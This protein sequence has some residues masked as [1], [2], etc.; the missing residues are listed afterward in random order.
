MI[1]TKDTKITAENLNAWISAF[2]H[3]EDQQPRLIKLGKYYDGINEIKKQGA[4]DGR[5]NYSIHVNLA[6]FITNVQTGYFMGKP[7][8][9]DFKEK[10]KGQENPLK[11][12]LL[13]IDSNN[14]AEEKN[15][16]LASDMSCYGVAYEVVMIDGDNENK[17]DILNRIKF[18]KLDAENTFLVVDDSI[19]QNPVCAVYM[20]AVKN[21][22]NV[23]EWRGYIYTADEIIEFNML[24]NQAVIGESYQHQFGEIPVIEYKNNCDRKGDYEAVTDQLDALSLTISNET[25]DLQ[26]I[27]NAILGI[28]G[29]TGTGDEVIKK[30]NETKVAKLP[31]GS[32]MEFVVK[33]INIDAV[34]HQIDQN[35]SLIYQ[36]TQTPDLTDENFG[37]TQT[38]VAMKYKLWGIEQCRITK[39]RY[40]RRSLFQRLRLIFNILS[41]SSGSIYDISQNIDFIFYKNLPEN[42]DE[43]VDFV[44]R[45]QSIVSTR[46]LL[47][48][49]P[50]VDDVDAEMEELKKENQ[51]NAER[52]AEAFASYKEE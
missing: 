2:K 52:E 37:G 25:D 43:I 19:L 3:Q 49:I 17:A 44:S 18:A 15:Y 41:L 51:E 13:Q 50:F 6:S 47:K 35:L 36:I 46:T 28:Y 32:N 10:E 22:N 39:E 29:A 38:G 23:E 40:F 11:K 27:A 5:P 7:V 4:T 1:I 48:Q 42:D 16:S 12:T 24:G 34:K 33:N 14:F 30:I 21:I 45:L 20:Y 31:V 9:Y 8:D 26:S